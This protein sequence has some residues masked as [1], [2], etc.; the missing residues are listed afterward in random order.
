MLSPSWIQLKLT[1]LEEREVTLTDCRHQLI[2]YAGPGRYY[3]SSN[4]EF[5]GQPRKSKYCNDKIKIK[6]YRNVEDAIEM[7]PKITGLI[8]VDVA[9]LNE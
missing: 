3:L 9:V 2:P 7:I 8:K 4:E 1:P 6:T 5:N